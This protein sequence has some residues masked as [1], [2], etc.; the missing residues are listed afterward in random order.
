[1]KKAEFKV[2][3]L[4][5]ICSSTILES[6]HIQ[7][8]SSTIQGVETCACLSGFWAAVSGPHRTVHHHFAHASIVSRVELQLEGW[9]DGNVGRQ[10]PQRHRDGAG[11]EKISDPYM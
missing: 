5:Y 9:R 3:L 10:R 1:M 8:Q 2:R 4:C 6:I 7:R 11:E